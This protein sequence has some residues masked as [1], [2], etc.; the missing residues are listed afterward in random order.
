[1]EFGIQKANM[2]AR[3]SNL[4]HANTDFKKKK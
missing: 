1:M 2:P 4:D 3:K